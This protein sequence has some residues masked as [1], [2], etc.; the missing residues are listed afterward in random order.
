LII[1]IFVFGITIDIWNIIHLIVTMENFLNYIVLNSEVRFGKPSIIGTRITVSDI[2]NWLACEM[3]IENILEDYPELKKEHILAC[4][5][6]AA[7]RES[8]TKII[9]A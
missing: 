4:L 5:Q 6:Y 3:T 9:A 7:K 2:L 1:L 8:I